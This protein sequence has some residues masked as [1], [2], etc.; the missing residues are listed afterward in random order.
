[1]KTVRIS[2]IN[3]LVT[4]QRLQRIAETLS[5]EGFQV[6][7]IGRELNGSLPIMDIAFSVKRFKLLFNKGAFFYAFYNLRLFFY[8][9]K[10]NRPDLL[11]SIDLDT[12]PANFLVSKIRRVPLI[13]DSHEYFT[14]VPE[15]VE[16]KTTKRVWELIER[17]IL[18]RIRFAMTVSE[19]IANEYRIKY[20]TSF[21]TIRNVPWKGEDDKEDNANEK[22]KAKYL[23]IYQGALNLGR[24]IEQMIECMEYLDKTI[25]LIVGE[26]DIQDK[27]KAMCKA[28]R[29]ESKVVFTGRIVPSELKKL[30][31]KCDL[32]LTL[33]EDIGLSYRYSLPNKLF[34]YIQA[35]I[36]VLC[37]DLP[38]IS[39]LVRKYE[40]GEVCVK[41]EPKMLAEQIY[42]ILSDV[43][44]T[45][46]FK[47][48]LNVA[49]A[50]LCWE[51]EEKKLK[52]LIK[53]AMN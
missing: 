43:K 22:Y 29:L 27:L 14:E 35:R 6:E 17:C 49:A 39:A 19:S 20:G 3:D 32:G 7:L 34:D 40:I 42:N 25:L 4:D 44:K 1:M 23:I 52:L 31:S 2:V 45:N 28:L 41:R 9:L 26:G 53:S 48:K 13:Y 38:E 51:N 8:L 46:N 18:P 11:F 16:R 24:G 12:L 47:I 5:G 33:E 15:L 30:T 10:I 36:P 21:E 50:A 37:S